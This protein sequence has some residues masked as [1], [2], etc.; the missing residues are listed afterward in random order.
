MA[1][2]ADYGI[3]EVRYNSEHTCDLKSFFAAM[4]RNSLPQVS[5]NLR[6]L[7]PRLSAIPKIGTFTLP[8]VQRVS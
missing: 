7:N 8:E 1:K 5:E 6:V 4:R 3:S 2:W